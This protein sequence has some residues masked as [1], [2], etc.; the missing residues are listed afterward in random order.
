MRRHVPCRHWHSLA[1]KPCVP[2]L[3]RGHPFA[4]KRHLQPLCCREFF[5]R[6][7]QRSVQ[8]VRSRPVQQRRCAC[9][10]LHYQLLP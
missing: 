4:V 2:A 6:A 7:W 1:F 5:C 9:V 8:R 10:Q 3:P